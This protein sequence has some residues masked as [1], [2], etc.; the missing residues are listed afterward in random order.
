MS[1]G[2]YMVQMWWLWWLWSCSLSCTAQQLNISLEKNMWY[3]AKTL[4]PEDYDI[5]YD[6]PRKYSTD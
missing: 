2:A 5:Q 4:S 3:Q 1:K 6:T